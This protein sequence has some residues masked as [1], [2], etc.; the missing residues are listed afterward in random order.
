MKQISFRFVSKLLESAEDV[1]FAF[2]V[3]GEEHDALVVLESLLVQQHRVVLHAVHFK[4]VLGRV[5]QVGEGVEIQHLIL[6]LIHR[7]KI[8]VEEELA[9]LEIFLGI[10]FFVHM[11]GF[12]GVNRQI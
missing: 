7:L 10:H 9:D 2:R 8:L 6:N 5:G 12:G 4:A 1:Q 3:D 11:T